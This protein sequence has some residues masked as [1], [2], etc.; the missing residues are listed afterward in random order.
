M[1]GSTPS[2]K[3][4]PPSAISRSA[5]TAGL[6]L[7]RTIG[8]A[9]LAT[10]RARSAAST[11]SAKRLSTFSRQSS[12]VTRATGTSKMNGMGETGE[13]TA[14]DRPDA[15]CRP[16]ESRGSLHDRVGLAT[17]RVLSEGRR[18]GVHPAV[19]SGRIIAL[20]WTVRR[21]NA[22][23]CR[24]RYSCESGCNGETTILDLPT[25]AHR[26]RAFFG[27]EGRPMEKSCP[28]FT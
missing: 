12:T 21:A 11:T 10:W 16:L 27:L 20:W 17:G 26:R 25:V 28:Q 7:Q 3:R 4:T 23:V 19:Q 24:P 1:V 8:L 2:L 6:L 15:N 13:Q 18:V 5:V 14:G 22:S 9:P